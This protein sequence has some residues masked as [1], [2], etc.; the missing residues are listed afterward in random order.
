MPRDDV[1][2]GAGAKSMPLGTSLVPTLSRLEDNTSNYVYS[3][4]VNP[5]PL[6]MK[7]E[8]YGRLP[9]GAG[10]YVL[11]QLKAIPGLRVGEPYTNISASKFLSKNDT[12][13]FVMVLS[14]VVQGSANVTEVIDYLYKFICY[15]GEKDYTSRS[16]LTQAGLEKEKVLLHS[17]TRL[18]ILNEVQE[19]GLER[20]LE[21]FDSNPLDGQSSTMLLTPSELKR[22]DEQLDTGSLYL[23]GY[24][25][26]L[27]VMSQGL[28]R[29][30]GRSISTLSDLRGHDPQG[31]PQDE[32]LS[33]GSLV[34][35][36]ARVSLSPG[37]TNT[38]VPYQPTKLSQSMHLQESNQA[39]LGDDIR[40]MSYFLTYLFV[41]TAYYKGM[42][43]RMDGVNSFVLNVNL[44]NRDVRPYA[45]ALLTA[46]I[47]PFIKPFTAWLGYKAEEK[48]S[49]VEFHRTYLSPFQKIMEHVD[50]EDSF[51]SQADQKLRELRRRLQEQQG[52]PICSQNSLIS[53]S[54][55]KNSS[56]DFCSED[57][58]YRDARSDALK[59]LYTLFQKPLDLFAWNFNISK[60]HENYSQFFEQGES[61]GGGSYGEVF[62]VKS[63]SDDQIYAIKE[64]T[65]RHLQ[66]INK[67]DDDASQFYRY[68]DIQ[69]N[70][71]KT[72][73]SLSC[74][75]IVTYYHCWIGKKARSTICSLNS[76]Q[77]PSRVTQKGYRYFFNEVSSSE[78]N[79]SAIFEM[80]GETLSGYDFADEVASSNQAM[81]TQNN[82]ETS[83][84]SCGA[85]LRKC[86]TTLKLHELETEGEYPEDCI[87]RPSSQSHM[88]TM[89]HSKGDLPDISS[90][91]FS[92]GHR[93][94]VYPTDAKSQAPQN[95]L[96][97]DSDNNEDTIL[98][99]QMEFCE[100]G[101]LSD[102]IHTWDN[103]PELLDN[104]AHFCWRITVQ[105][106]VAVAYMH[107]RKI[108]HYDIKPANILL[109]DD[110]TAKL[111]DFGG[112][113]NFNEGLPPEFSRR[114]TPLYIAPDMLDWA[115][116]GKDI[117]VSYDE[118]L[119]QHSKGDIYSLGATL[120]EL[121]YRPSLPQDL[122]PLIIQAQVGNLQPCPF[123]PH[124]YIPILLHHMMSTDPAKRHTA[125][126]LL[127]VIRSF[128]IPAIS[129][130]LLNIPGSKH[131]D[132]IQHVAYY[133]RNNVLERDS[134]HDLTDLLH[135]VA[136][137]VITRDHPRKPL[138]PKITGL[139][140]KELV[141]THVEHL[142]MLTDV[143]Q[144]TLPDSVDICDLRPDVLAHLVSQNCTYGIMTKLDPYLLPGDDS[145]HLDSGLSS[146]SSKDPSERLLERSLE[147]SLIEPHVIERRSQSSSPISPE[148]RP[149]ASNTETVADE[150]SRRECDTKVVLHPP[151]PLILL[152]TSLDHEYIPSTIEETNAGIDVEEYL[153]DAGAYFARAKDNASSFVVYR[154]IPSYQVIGEGV[155]LYPLRMHYLSIALG[156]AEAILMYVFNLSGL[157]ISR[158]PLTAHL[159][160]RFVYPFKYLPETLPIQFNVRTLLST[161]PDL[162]ILEKL[163][164]HQSCGI[165]HTAV[166]IAEGLRGLRWCETYVTLEPVQTYSFGADSIQ[167][168][169]DIPS[170]FAMWPI[171][172]QVQVD[173]IDGGMTLLKGE[174][175]VSNPSTG[176]MMSHS[177]EYPE[178]D[179]AF[180]IP[181]TINRSQ[182]QL[183]PQKQPQTAY[184]WKYPYDVFCFSF[185]ASALPQDS[186]AF[187]LPMV[188]PIEQNSDTWIN[189]MTPRKYRDRD[190]SISVF[191][192]TRTL[193]SSLLTLGLPVVSLH[194][195]GPNPSFLNVHVG[196]H[197]LHFLWQGR[198]YVL[199]ISLT[200][201]WP[202]IL[203]EYLF[204]FLPS[205]V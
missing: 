70:E 165:L 169:I 170:A 106:L 138:R 63:R 108:V 136:R 42:T 13:D 196:V 67:S 87:D 10:S 82:D 47:V 27:D 199:D 71:V 120:L 172:S 44:Y 92:S 189:I 171:G 14:R 150:S 56:S 188:T 149:S 167:L 16:F 3:I 190:A 17:T 83:S 94:R 4:A 178:E 35:S 202:S 155:P 99:I 81:T 11:V 117:H 8:W 96:G 113:H 124:G 91:N 118:C 158:T 144:I 116:T 195:D 173:G 110:F 200:Q 142:L 9:S 40:L 105:L 102:C 157:S 74:P 177:F 153:Q 128:S 134:L 52:A 192:V 127:M 80:M 205:F 59:T 131:W 135:A 180:T 112:S 137:H 174:F 75:Y 61:L 58:N 76:S 26:V 85:I 179:P 28:A 197:Q 104:P 60:D 111:G 30:R 103:T 119:E 166:I 89:V 182:D 164:S 95:S 107:N 79:D 151:S 73:S 1:H 175:V 152:L 147:R 100:K 64:V 185:F 34:P 203:E 162:S 156:L 130:V 7:P 57:K 24:R 33:S 31:I 154:E 193:Y 191:N 140:G 55:E 184:S 176:E 141:S 69:L 29:G 98:Y 201:D 139:R 88:S 186:L 46:R 114:V 123:D 168:D 22:R 181:G 23:P 54:C 78:T 6:P 21:L 163:E 25:M 12:E 90:Q 183:R 49:L 101:A 20:R 93:H 50:T 45:S 19:K 143:S 51:V 146:C 65:L 32:G 43:D 145:Q 72:L 148:I 129:G 159:V 109:T 121:W 2:E 160:V 68:L 132:V 86:S 53:H 48:I 37:T 15:N 62:R 41:T 126:H 194:L 198:G 18:S 125:Q 84:V 97:T 122:R 77:L 5:R 115:L 39:S 161:V 204:S 66:M 187:S 38:I 36:Q 133:L